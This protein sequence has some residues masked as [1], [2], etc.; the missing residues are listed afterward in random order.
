MR[1]MEPA[2]AGDVERN[3]VRV[4]WEAFGEG[5]PTIALAADVVDRPLA[6]LE[7]AGALSRPPLPGDHP[8]R[9]RLWPAR[10]VPRTRPRT[11]TWSSPPTS[12]PCSMPPRP[13]APCS[14]GSRWV[15][16]GASCSPLTSPTACSASSVWDRRWRW[17]RCPPS[18]RSIRSTSGS[19]T[20]DGWAKYNRFHWLEGGYP[21]FLEFFFAQLFTEPHSTKQIEDFVGWG[22][23]I[24]PSTL[25]AIEDGLFANQRERVR[26]VC[27]RITRSGARDPR[28]RGRDPCPTPQARRSP[29]SPEASS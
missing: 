2:S 27:E 9:A 24:D 11:A 10:I 17:R 23:E 14:P 18:A 8:R 5:E 19:T 4:H 25:V 1:A 21:D 12:S 28:R 6:S 26:A 3:G 16:C 20:T 29:T 22:L 13:I 15:R 7:V